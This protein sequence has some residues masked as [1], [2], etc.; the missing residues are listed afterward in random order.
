MES[1]TPYLTSTITGTYP[2]V[3]VTPETWI[4]W[5]HY[6]EPGRDVSQSQPWEPAEVPYTPEDEIARQA[7]IGETV[8]KLNDD[9]QRAAIEPVERL[10]A[11]LTAERDRLLAEVLGLRCEVNRSKALIARLYDDLHRLQA[12]LSQAQCVVEWKRP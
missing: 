10:V 12:E 3:D 11:D 7:S 8:R 1:E 6:L 2:G 4:H 5:P 9:L